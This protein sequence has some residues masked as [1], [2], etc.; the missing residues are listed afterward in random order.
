M[1]VCA[2]QLLP[3][4]WGPLPLQG[5]ARPLVKGT[6]AFPHMVHSGPPTW[7]TQ[8]GGASHARHP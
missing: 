4:T 6:I 5:G 1:G 8:P 3:V 2:C 7:P